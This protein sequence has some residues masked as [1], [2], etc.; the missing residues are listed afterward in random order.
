MVG[1]GGGQ[2][3]SAVGTMV[4]FKA[5]WV[6]EPQHCQG[7]S[8]SLLELVGGFVTSSSC[9]PRSG[10]PELVGDR[11]ASLQEQAAAQK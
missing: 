5:S 9:G 7:S 11:P 8:Q 1:E 6:I 4:S 10:G 2:A 3:A